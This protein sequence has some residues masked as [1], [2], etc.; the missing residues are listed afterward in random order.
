MAITIFLEMTVSARREPIVT[1]LVLFSISS[2]KRFGRPIFFKFWLLPLFY[3]FQ[4]FMDVRLNVYFRYCFENLAKASLVLW[5]KAYFPTSIQICFGITLTS[6]WLFYII[7]NHLNFL[8]VCVL[9]CE[10]IISGL[11][12]FFLAAD[13]LEP[14]AHHLKYAVRSVFDNIFIKKVKHWLMKS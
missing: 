6:S 9:C 3:A 1:S 13:P 12:F 14:V 11:G 8:Y 4:E 10:A 2:D 5:A 7:H